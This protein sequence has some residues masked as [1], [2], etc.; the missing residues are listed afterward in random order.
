MAT[1]PSLPLKGPV[2]DVLH[3]E[4]RAQKSPGGPADEVITSIR[5]RYDEG[6]QAIEENLKQWNSEVTTIN[7]YEGRRLVSQESTILGS[8]EPPPKSWSY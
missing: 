6:G 4:L 1:D 2:A 3:E 8:Q 5:T 7:R